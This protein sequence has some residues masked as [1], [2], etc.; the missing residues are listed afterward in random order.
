MKL[1]PLTQNRLA[2]VDDEDFEWLQKWKWFY[3]KNNRE[4]GGY[5]EHSMYQNGRLYN[6]KMHVEIMKYC[7]LWQP[8]FEIDHINTCCTDNRKENLRLAT[9]KENHYNHRMYSFNTSG[10]CGVDWRRKNKRW[11]ARLRLRSVWNALDSPLMKT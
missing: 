4:T 3:H 8:G 6:V 7:G 2:V 11:R 10:K 9:S 5:V 1:I